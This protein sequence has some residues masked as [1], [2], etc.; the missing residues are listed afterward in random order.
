MATKK[1]FFKS[2]EHLSF[3]TLVITTSSPNRTS[4]ALGNTWRV[5]RWENEEGPLRRLAIGH[6]AGPGRR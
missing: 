4:C 3:L 1:L 5:C 6:D 2:C